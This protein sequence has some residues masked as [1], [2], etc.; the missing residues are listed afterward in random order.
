MLIQEY[1]NG[2]IVDRELFTACMGY[3]DMAYFFFISRQLCV[4]VMRNM[5]KQMRIHLSMFGLLICPLSSFKVIILYVFCAFPCFSPQEKCHA[6]TGPTCR[7]HVNQSQS[8]I[9]NQ[10]NEH[11]NT[12]VGTSS[13]N[14]FP[15]HVWNAV[16]SNDD[17][18]IQY[19]KGHEIYVD[20]SRNRYIASTKHHCA[21]FLELSRAKWVEFRWALSAVQQSRSLTV[22]RVQQPMA[23]ASK[24]L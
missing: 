9:A 6:W 11:R 2:E 19:V 8:D 23:A 21:V 15:F 13:W 5:Q 17:F 1:W 7:W 4:N 16:F 22:W 20:W 3:G 12:Q 24:P 10:P 14:L 18:H